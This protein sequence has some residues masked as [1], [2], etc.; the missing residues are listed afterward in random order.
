M[1]VM[2]DIMKNA[3]KVALKDIVLRQHFLGAPDLLDTTIW[4]KGTYTK[5]QLEDRKK[6]IEDFYEFIVQRKSAG[7]QQWSDWALYQKEKKTAL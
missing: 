6:F 1:L 2:F 3:P 7:I 4:P 5:K